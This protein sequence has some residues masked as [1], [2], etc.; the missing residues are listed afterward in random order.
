MDGQDGALDDLNQKVPSEHLAMARKMAGMH[1][2]DMVLDM[3]ESHPMRDARKSATVPCHVRRREEILACEACAGDRTCCKAHEATACAYQGGTNACED[4][5]CAVMLLVFSQ[6][7][8]VSTHSLDLD[9]YLQRCCFFYFDFCDDDLPLMSL[10][11]ELSACFPL[12]CFNGHLHCYCCCN[13][14]IVH[15]SAVFRPK[16][17]SDVDPMCA[18]LSF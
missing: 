3:E 2:H 10:F 12:G 14:V 11:I 6:I 8:T 4:G 5:P 17:L 16:C 15:A 13:F 1:L 7:L 18:I 9:V